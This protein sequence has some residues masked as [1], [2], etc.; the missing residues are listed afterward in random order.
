MPQA[1]S[2]SWSASSTGVG[3]DR[4]RC[5][6]VGGGGLSVRISRLGRTF[7]ATPI[8]GRKPGQRGGAHVVPVGQELLTA[9]AVLD[10]DDAG[11]GELAHR[12][13]DGVD[14]ASKAPGQGLPGRHP[15]A[16]AVPVAKQEGVQA[17]RSVGDGRVD[18]P[19]GDD[20]EP[21]FLDDE[22]AGGG[23]LGVRRW[24]FSG[25]CDGLSSWCAEG[26]QG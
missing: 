14:R 17:E 25:H 9:A 3:A 15:G 2:G 21:W 20:R 12:P 4:P 10:A 7:A 5:E 11:F 24:G 18:H 22:D 8:A 19:F 6:G 16:G 13:V 26:G 1:S 23:E